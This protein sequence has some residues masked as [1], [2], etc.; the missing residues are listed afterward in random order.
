MT[1]PHSIEAEQGIIG[2]IL[3]DPKTLPEALEKVTPGGDFFF[4]LRHETIYA[5]LVAMMNAGKSIDLITVQ[6]HLKDSNQL[7]AIGGITYLMA[8]IDAVPSAANLSHYIDIAVEKSIRRKLIA[9]A[10]LIGTKAMDEDSDLPTT[11]DRAESL[12]LK[13]GEALIGESSTPSTKA[14]VHRTINYLEERL[15]N[16]GQLSGIST[17]YS[18]FDK[19]TGGMTAGQMI[20][21]A[22]R[23]STGKTSWAMNIADYIAIEQKLPVGVFSL[24]MTSDQLMLRMMCSRSGVGI[25]KC[26]DG[27]FLER[28]FTLLTAAAAKLGSAPLFIDDTPGLDLNRLRSKARRMLHAHEIKVLVIDYLQLLASDSNNRYGD[29]SRISTGIKNLAKE[30]GIPIIV[31]AQLSRDIEKDDGKPRK[32]RMSDLK[33][34]G[35]IEQDAD[36]IAILYAAHPPDFVIQEGQPRPVNARICKARDGKKD[37]DVELEFHEECVRF[38]RRLD[39]D[40]PQP[41]GWLKR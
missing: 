7:E 39:L 9:T 40:N 41:R 14:L 3:Q 33:E 22:G 30:L 28:D 23:P 8:L 35:Q 32:P 26:K 17:G 21:I 25:R 20:V 34:S 2:S 11:L 10:Q 12:I 1:P 37:V 31:L 15:A 19:F 27:D 6:Q 38:K 4:D 29:I 18:E 16:K 13:A 5:A 24:E 36:V